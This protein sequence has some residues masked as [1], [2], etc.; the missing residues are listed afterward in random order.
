MRSEGRDYYVGPGDAS[1]TKAGDEHDI[2]EIYEDM[3]GCWFEEPCSPGGRTGHLHR[4]AEKAKGM[5][6]RTASL[7]PDF[8]E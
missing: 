4:D 8:P 2:I 3:E 6:Y 5:W 7:P 1:C